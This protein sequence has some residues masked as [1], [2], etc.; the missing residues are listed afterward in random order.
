MAELAGRS[1][2]FEVGETWV[3]W[4]K[5]PSGWG[6]RARV[7][8]RVWTCSESVEQ[9]GGGT[10]SIL[11]LGGGCLF[12]LFGVLIRPISK[13]NNSNNSNSDDKI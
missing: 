1:C 2:E 12:A 3:R 8:M 6:S 9:E 10:N 11:G 4:K 13:F 5:P 7:L